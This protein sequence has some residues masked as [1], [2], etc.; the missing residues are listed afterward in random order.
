MGVPGCQRPLLNPSAALSPGHA[1]LHRRQERAEF[2]RATCD[3]RTRSP[4]PAHREFRRERRAAVTLIER[5]KNI[6]LT[7]STEWPIIAAEP[8]STGTLIAGYV[9]PLAAI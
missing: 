1:T 8:A 7:P 9:V 6:C 5:V 2:G 3:D 4:R